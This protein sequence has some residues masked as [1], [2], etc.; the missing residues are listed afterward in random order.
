MK[1][2]DCT[3]IYSLVVK[4]VATDAKGFRLDSRIGKIVHSVANDSA[5]LRRLYGVVLPGH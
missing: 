4:E 1:I 2:I 5:P 3:V